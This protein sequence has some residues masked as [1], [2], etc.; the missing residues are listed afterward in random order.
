MDSG[1]LSLRDTHGPSQRVLAGT[2]VRSDETLNP[3]AGMFADRSAVIARVALGS[4]R[5]GLADRDR[6]HGKR[7]GGKCRGSGAGGQGS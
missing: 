4:L 7:T 1:G 5:P 3:F 2:L 6:S